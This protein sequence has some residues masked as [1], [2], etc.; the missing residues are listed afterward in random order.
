MAAYNFK[1]DEQHMTLEVDGKKTV[2]HP[3]TDQ[4][5]EALTLVANSSSRFATLSC[6][7][8]HYIQTALGSHG[9]LIL[10]YQDGST[11]NHFQSLETDLPFDKISQAFRG[12]A[13]GESSWKQG[14]QWEPI[15]VNKGS[16]SLKRISMVG[17]LLFVVFSIP[18]FLKAIGKDDPTNLF[19]LDLTSYMTFWSYLMVLSSLDNL[20]N[21]KS[22]RGRVR[23]GA[24]A[25]IILAS[26][27]TVF[28]I[29]DLF[30]R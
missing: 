28:L 6:S 7:K 8:M 10:E 2:N 9:G 17:L 30:K 26:F 15:R 21:I 18:L 25:S 12:Y 24:I 13:R 19:G 23:A 16:N 22:I 27:F 29:I 1:K 11:D 5:D 3:T 14:F 4:I 20:R